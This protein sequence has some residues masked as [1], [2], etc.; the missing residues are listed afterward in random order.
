M[1]C[2]SIS[3]AMGLLFA[4]QQAVQA[5][6][7]HHEASD[8]GSVEVEELASGLGVV[9]GME[10]LDDGRLMLTEREGRVRLLDL[11]SG[12]LT[13]ITGL[14]Q[15]RTGGQGGLLDLASTP[16]APGWYYIT[17][18]ASV[19][20]RGV[21]VLSRARLEGTQLTDWQDLLITRSGTG[22]T[23]HFG[24]RIAFDGKGYVY[25][26]TGDRGERPNGQNLQTHAG[27]IMRLMLNGEI[28]SD[29]PFIGK[30][31]ALPEIW[32]YG[33]RNPQGLAYDAEHG[34]LWENEH[35][36]RGGDEIN[37][38]K[39]GA[40]YGWP[41]LSYGKE[42][43]GPIDVGEGKEA[44]GMESPVKVYIPSIAPGSLMF[45]TGNAFPEWRGNLFSGALALTH[46]NRV[47]L[48]NSGEAV[49]EERLLGEMNERIRD[50]EQ[51]P[52]GLIYLSTDSGR[53]LR[54]QPAS[55]E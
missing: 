18:V 19:E 8:S 48:D 13:E 36:P 28:P 9:W 17:W 29:N 33:H 45:Y 21:T 23:R 10:F 42:Y 14:P 53:I 37:L 22:T 20:N 47:D 12:E 34:R 24:G 54:L 50:V 40:N 32:S 30:A 3:L 4:G 52:D 7:V 44:P 43:W 15:I 55:A 26:S 16:E 31:G 39:S 35:G 51:G 49:A 38:I 27:S 1:L 11:D 41:T 25:F 5:E 6:I 2:R 46:L